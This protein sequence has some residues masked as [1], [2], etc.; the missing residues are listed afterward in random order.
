MTCSVFHKWCNP[1]DESIDIESM[2]TGWNVSHQRLA[3]QRGLTSEN[4]TNLIGQNE[5]KVPKSASVRLRL[6][7]QQRAVQIS[8]VWL[9]TQSLFPLVEKSSKYSPLPQLERS[10]SGSAFG[11]QENLRWRKDM[12]HW[13]QNSE[14]MD[15]YARSHP[16]S[17]IQSDSSSLRA[18]TSSYSSTLKEA[19]S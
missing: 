9:C 16:L 14:K 15:K 19:T 13:R 8:H 18:F 7:I 1:L 2:K 17:R 6:L 4:V 12:T 3:T 5:M 11:S 10:P